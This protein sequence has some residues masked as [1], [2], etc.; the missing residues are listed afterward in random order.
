MSL[1]K[2]PNELDTDTNL[3]LVHDNLRVVLAADYNPGDTSIT[4]YDPN[5]VIKT[6][7]PTG[8]ITLTEQCSDVSLRAISFYY[9]SVDTTNLIF[10]GLVLLSCFTDC[11]KPANITNVT[12]NVIA[13]HHNVI[14]DAVIAI[15]HFVGKEG[16]F[17]GD[18]ITGR[19]NY[20]TQIVFT[21]NAWFSGKN[22]LGLIPLT[23]TF[24]DN[25]FRLGDGP[26]TYIWD[27]GD[28]TIINTTYASSDDIIPVTHIYT[29]PGE[30]AVSLTVQN[31]YGE[32]TVTFSR[33]VNARIP[34]PEEAT[35]TFSPSDSQFLTV[36][37]SPSDGPYT[38][39]PVIRSPINSQINLQVPQGAHTSDPNYSY[40][41]EE[42]INGIP[43]DPIEEY[44]W[45]FGDD[46]SHPNNYEATALYSVGGQY[47][48]VLRVDTD[49]GA[50][51]ITKYP[52][53][54]NIVELQNIWLWLYNGS[55]THTDETSYLSYIAPSGPT[56][57]YE[58]GLLSETFKTA[59]NNSFT[60]D[61]D[62]SFLDNTHND[63]QARLEFRRNVSITPQNTTPSG[64]GGTAMIYYAQENQIV[65]TGYT[66]FT[67]IYDLNLISP[68]SRPW[69]W[70]C[71]N[72]P[73]SSYFLFGADLSNTGPHQPD[74][75]ES[76]WPWKTNLDLLTLSPTTTEM[77][78]ASGDFQNGAEE[79]LVMP[80]IYDN[81]GES[82]WGNFAV[83]RTAW[84]G[85]V[86]Y[87]LRNSNIGPYFRI[88]NFYQT[89]GTVGEE[90]MA[91]TK[92][93]DMTGPI[94]TE[95]ELV[96]LSDGLF[97]FNNTGNM[98]AYNDTTGV[99][100]TG[101]VSTS[102]ISFAS[103]QDSTV[104][105]YNDASNTL[106]ATTDGDRN[107]YLSYDYSQYAFIKFSSLDLTFSNIGP[108]PGWKDRTGSQFAMSMY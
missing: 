83:Y 4:V 103:L 86:G 102:S 12:L 44:T 28:G 51:R 98:T 72:S 47:D 68:I 6:F 30:Y 22:T 15:Q 89:V 69:N 37:P 57:S 31:Q 25:S 7:P 19:L 104:E 38:T 90:F 58:F 23:T 41:G 26:L 13:Q 79:L 53:C 11:V 94:K 42:L 33:F 9:A 24:T 87:I 43:R 32:D 106:L 107:A 74:L 105:N 14:K 96:A 78:F 29:T 8:I 95:G 3:Y 108:R 99:W 54:F 55:Y 27:F 67:D 100:E 1:S 35:I 80:A 76:A 21:P 17:G 18:T 2:Y 77:E 59:S 82:L 20:L 40:A 36:I 16:L 5:N 66:A 46:L 52:G 70:C 81:T 62:E 75:E 88:S 45:S 92:L 63:E 34:A 71:L 64:S 39:T 50:Y 49:F 65:V 97:F 91:L 84:K 10:S 85:S 73:S 56:H 101:G 61:R 48:L 60:I 93:N